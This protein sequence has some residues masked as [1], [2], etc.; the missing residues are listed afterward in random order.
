M[1]NT[2]VKLE[3]EADFGCF[4]DPLSGASFRTYPFATFSALKQIAYAIAD[5][6]NAY[7]KP[8]LLRICNPVKYANYTFTYGGAYRK[9]GRGGFV[10]HSTVLVN[11]RYQV[12]YEV[13]SRNEEGGSPKAIGLLRQLL[14]YNI[15][16]GR[17]KRTP[18]M[19]RGE[20]LAELCRAVAR[21]GTSGR[22][23]HGSENATDCL[24]GQ[25]Q[26]RIRS[27]LCRGEMRTWSGSLCLANF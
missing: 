8:V 25:I 11:P 9:Q 20:F 6:H 22:N 5:T 10:G 15:A 12:L 16:E 17:C 27:R 21:D 24:R 19:G 14:E 18:F 13:V 1:D 26:W 7:A 3:I 23:Y 2:T 4:T